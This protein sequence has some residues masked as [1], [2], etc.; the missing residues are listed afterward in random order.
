MHLNTGARG[1]V[2]EEDH[3][4]H[5]PLLHLQFPGDISVRLVITQYL[6]HV[7]MGNHKHCRY[8]GIR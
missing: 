7:A 4:V 2:Q 5:A 1:T 6:H 3:R 8:I